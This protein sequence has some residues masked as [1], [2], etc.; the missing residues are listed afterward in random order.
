MS[1]SQVEGR[2]SSSHSFLSLPNVLLLLSSAS[3]PTVHETEEVLD[4]LFYY[5]SH[6][7]FLAMR[8][9]QRFGISNPSPG[10]IFR[11]STAYST[12]TYQGMGSG[13][14]GD[15][16]AM[17]A[18]ILLDDEARKVVLDS[19]Q[20][21]GHL[22][23]PLIKVMS[24]F[25]SMGLSYQMPLQVENMAGTQEIFGQG[26]FESPSGELS[27][28]AALLSNTRTAISNIHHRNKLQCSVS[29]FQNFNRSA[30]S[31]L[32]GYLPLSLRCCKET[33]S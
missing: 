22:R 1:Q 18:A 30:P 29:S 32:R 6:P 13:K 17:A 11:V 2:Q 9:I 15:L 26:A 20:A 28:I 33:M 12:G 3:P 7:P 5:P 14:Y 10:M 23:E 27:T 21:H 16:G 4:S 25:R 31:N 8:V 19:D 24:F